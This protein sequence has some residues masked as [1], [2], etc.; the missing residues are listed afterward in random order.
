MLQKT[1]TSEVSTTINTKYHVLLPSEEAHHSF[2]QKRGPAGYAQR[3]HP[4]L[5]E[6]IYE[7]VSEGI[8]D[9]QEVK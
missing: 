3:I 9:K 7:L 2:H 4:K 5:T 8:S 6:K 1:L